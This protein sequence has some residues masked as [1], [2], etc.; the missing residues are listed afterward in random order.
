MT[1]IEKGVLSCRAEY[2]ATQLAP[3]PATILLFGTVN[4]LL[5]GNRKS[6]RDKNWDAKTAAFP[7]FTPFTRTQL[8]VK[9]ELPTPT[10]LFISVFAVPVTGSYAVKSA[11]QTANKVMSCATPGL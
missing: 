6:L 2:R 11:N 8:P 5:L 10:E 7:C 1:S 9:P 3:V 4:P